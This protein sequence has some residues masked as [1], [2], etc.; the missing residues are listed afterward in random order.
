MLSRKQR[1]NCHHNQ[2]KILGLF[3]LLTSTLSWDVHAHPVGETTDVVR[4]YTY[5]AR[6]QLALAR[7]SASG[8]I[9]REHP[10]QTDGDLLGALGLAELGTGLV[11]Q[12]VDDLLRAIA[13]GSGPE[14]HRFRWHLALLN[15]WGLQS[16]VDTRFEEVRHGAE[17]LAARD[18]IRG[19]KLRLIL[20]KRTL[21]VSPDLARSDLEAFLRD[22]FSLPQGLERAR[23][24]LFVAEAAKQGQRGGGGSSSRWV[25]LRF[26]ALNQAI[27][28]AKDDRELLS[29][30]ELEMV[31]LYREQHR[32]SD[33]L[34]IAKMALGRA[35]Q[36]LTPNIA[37]QL[38]AE[39]AR[40]EL[41]MGHAP[42]A[43]QAFA[44]AF[45][46]AESIRADLPKFD[47]KGRSWFSQTLFPLYLERV[48]LLMEQSAI[49][50]SEVSRHA[51]LKEAILTL[52][53]IN[54]ASLEEF[55]G[56][57]CGVPDQKVRLTD[58]L[59]N[60]EVQ[61]AF[62]YPF[63]AGDHGYVILASGGDIEVI[64]LTGI[65]ARSLQ[66][67]VGS[68]SKVLAHP[69]SD[70][71][72]LAKELYGLLFEPLEPMLKKGQVKRIVVIPDSLFRKIPLA[73]LHDGH[74]YLVTRYA[75]ATLTGLS[76]FN[77]K[78]E[79]ENEERIFVAGLA[80]PGPVVDELPEQVNRE[81][82]NSARARGI[83]GFGIAGS[84]PTHSVSRE[85]VKEALRLPGVEREVEVLRPMA[86]SVL[87]DTTFTRDEL[88]RTFH[89]QR[90][91][92]LHIASHGVIGRSAQQSFILTYDHLLKFGDLERLLQ[93][94]HQ[95]GHLRLL[96]LSACH[97][98]EGD[99]QAPLG[100]SG[101]ALKANVPRAVGSLW[102]VDDQAT[103]RL[104]QN[105]YEGFLNEGRSASVALSESQQKL[106]EQSEFR[107]PFYWAP[108]I[109]VG[110]WW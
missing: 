80:V 81:V 91:S 71:L 30:S 102:P 14:E 109:L 21:R 41:S 25:A 40:S 67:K 83:G 7:E 42:Q 45:D 69:E 64:P 36:S 46:T 6:G 26:S 78:D 106:L 100:L 44:S 85:V 107:H 76:L 68:F 58:L 1:F 5:L 28:D 61:T 12:G 90:F 43:L 99:E 77:P 74:G 57:T 35:G 79:E 72:P 29:T 8:Q 73:A 92:A 94:G 105:F 60:G 16:P 108:F 101:L 56:H 19:L 3:L 52:E 51:L 18:N 95:S 70:P 48:G 2:L 49:N 20:I 98:A 66:Q 110:R 13:L 23:L 97:S 22:I 32:D 27:A 88:Y 9:D 62:L 34:Q 38:E 33:A 4:I 37:W 11:E 47:E 89:D 82:M 15:L 10:N 75:F 86:G 103:V 96:T 17:S 59:D 54:R 24:H 93:S 87:T 104:M 55:L 50:R 84:S 53:G 63:V 31:R 65:N 39:R